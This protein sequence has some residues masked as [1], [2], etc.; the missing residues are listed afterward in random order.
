MK[1]VQDTVVDVDTKLIL[2]AA[3]A[4]TDTKMRTKLEEILRVNRPI[5]EFTEYSHTLSCWKSYQIA[6]MWNGLTDWVVG[7]GG[8]LLLSKFNGQASCLVLLSVNIF[9]NLPY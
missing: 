4:R 5:S 1:Y 9:P 8:D 6:D 3:E 2:D 7:G